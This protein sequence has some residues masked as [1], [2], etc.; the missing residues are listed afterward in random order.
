MFGSLL[1]ALLFLQQPQSAAP[2]QG[3]SSPPEPAQTTS[4]EDV[5]ARLLKVKRIYV[6]SFGEDAIE[7]Q[8]QAMLVASLTESKKFVVTEN[9]DR[10]DAVLKG[11]GLE[12]SS[13]E[14]HA[15]DDSTSVA[16]AGGGHSSSV[17]GSW[18]HGTGSV[19]GTSSG[20]F[21]S[22]AAGISDS[23][24][25]TETVNDARVAVRLVDRDGD[26][27]WATS[28]ESKGAKYKGAV[29]DVADKVVKQLLRDV[30]KATKAAVESPAPEAQK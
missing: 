14:V 27:I 2:S 15:Y 22:R 29:A 8:V 26:V 21:A 5:S 13:Q 18:V 24:L 12:K 9:K 7:K 1:L 30:A 23:S 20:G 10:A 19:S 25:N 28:Q 3:A 17:N 16:G 11:S 6:E 4:E